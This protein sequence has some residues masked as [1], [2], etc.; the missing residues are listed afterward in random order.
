MRPEDEAK[1]R[2]LISETA[3][4]SARESVDYLFLHMGIDLNDPKELARMKADFSHLRKLRVGSELVK[5]ASI[6][7]CAGAVI[8]AL[9]WLFYEGLQAWVRLKAGMPPK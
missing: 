1:V 4:M 9:I 3:K 2:Q 8:T 7:T 5:A 6:K